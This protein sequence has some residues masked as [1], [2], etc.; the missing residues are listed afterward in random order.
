ME[1]TSVSPWLGPLDRFFDQR[2]M[3]DAAENIYEFLGAADGD[4]FL[5]QRSDATAAE[6][7]LKETR[8]G[9]LHVEL[10]AVYTGLGKAQQHLDY[11]R[12]V[13]QHFV[14]KR[15]RRKFQV[16]PEWVTFCHE[17]LEGFGLSRGNLVRRTLL[18]QSYLRVYVETPVFLYALRAL[19][20]APRWAGWFSDLTLNWPYLQSRL[21]RPPLIL[22]LRW[23]D[24]RWKTAVKYRMRQYLAG[25]GIAAKRS[26]TRIQLLRLCMAVQ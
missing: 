24:G 1:D 13:G 21:E 10:R 22:D 6:R 25:N 19:Q 16:P 3:L 17:T 26:L 20:G 4:D 12:D 14:F 23:D 9:A 15:A 18:L 7:R 8:W 11:V 2:H 5:D